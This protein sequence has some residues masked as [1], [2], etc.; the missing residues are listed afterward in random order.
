MEKNFFV[1]RRKGLTFEGESEVER[2]APNHLLNVT[3]ARFSLSRCCTPTRRL[4]PQIRIYSTWVPNGGASREKVCT[5]PPPLP[6]P[7]PF[8]RESPFSVVSLSRFFREGTTKGHALR[9]VTRESRYAH[10]TPAG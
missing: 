9:Y 6:P 1:E 5:L 8:H 3:K 2:V 10:I 7:L 4:F